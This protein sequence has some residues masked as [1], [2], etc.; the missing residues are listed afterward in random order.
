MLN[1][2]LIGLLSDSH[3]QVGITRQAVELLV[4][5]GAQMLIHLGD[6]GSELVIDALL[7]TGP[8]GRTPIEAHLVFGNT[9]ADRRALARYARHLDIHVDDPVGALSLDA[10]LLVFTHGDNSRA[11]TAAVD[12][13][14]RYLCHGHTH[15]VADYRRGA[16]RII[17]P[18]A[19]FR[20]A[21]PS[22]A[23]LDPVNDDLRV[24]PLGP[25]PV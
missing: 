19:L 6:I 25:E 17:N 15:R 22:V 8:D 9:D 16:T 7:C 2:A 24:L 3:G 10:G 12:E 13:N 18:G 23:L 21:C 5:R 1:V 14:A 11:L 20:T 4:Q